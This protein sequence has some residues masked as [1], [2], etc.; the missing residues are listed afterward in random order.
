M[1]K[2]AIKSKKTHRRGMKSNFMSPFIRHVFL[3][4]DMGAVGNW[5]GMERVE[6]PTTSL[7]QQNS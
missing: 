3:M 5:P 2:Y 4:V 7:R 1:E 6:D